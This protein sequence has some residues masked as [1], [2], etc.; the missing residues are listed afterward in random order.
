MSRGLF[1]RPLGELDVFKFLGFADQFMNLFVSLVLPGGGCG[2]G[3]VAPSGLAFCRLVLGAEMAA[4]GFFAG[5]GVAGHEF[6]K[7][8][9]VGDATGKFEV[10]IQGVGFFYLTPGDSEPPIR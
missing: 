7:L 1:V 3:F 9:K 6:A 10:F 4:A 5:E 8:H 2:V